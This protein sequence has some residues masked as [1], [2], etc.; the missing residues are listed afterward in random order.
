MAEYKLIS[1]LLDSFAM[2][3]P[4]SE[5]NGVRCCP[6]MDQ[7]TKDKYIVKIISIPASQTKLDA[8][9]LTGAYPSPEAAALYF[10]DLADDI[11]KEVQTLS[12]LSKMEGFL[13]YTGSQVVPMENGT[14]YNVYLLGTYK[15]SLSKFFS[16]EPM[17]HL[18]AINLGLDLCAALA[19]C[20]R[21]GYLYADLKPENV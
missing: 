17:T 20:R 19:V 8:L 15:K 6:A 11:E 4:V 16:R 10:K 13:P 7:N 1:P 12:K 14:G 9:L 5:H 2:G 18:R 3:D 21:S